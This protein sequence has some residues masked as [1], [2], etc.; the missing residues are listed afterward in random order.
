M[1][2]KVIKNINKPIKIDYEV[3]GFI[4]FAI[5]MKEEEDENFITII[6]TRNNKKYTIRKKSIIS[7]IEV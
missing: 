4:K 2:I 6:G 3:N 1:K 7:I 5:G